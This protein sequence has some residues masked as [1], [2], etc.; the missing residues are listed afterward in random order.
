[1]NIKKLIAP[2]VNKSGY[3]SIRTPYGLK[4]AHRL[5]MK[6]WKPIPNSE[7]LTIDHLDSNKRYNDMVQ[8][9]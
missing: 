4:T 5:V 1:M 6:I 8:E 2:L 7:E 3:L 9:N